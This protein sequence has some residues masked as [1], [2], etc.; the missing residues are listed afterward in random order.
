[1][2]WGTTQLKGKHLGAYKIAEMAGSRSFI[3]KLQG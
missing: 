3:I 2:E 1:M